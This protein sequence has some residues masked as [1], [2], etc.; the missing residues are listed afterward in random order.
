M[1]EAEIISSQLDFLNLTGASGV[2]SGDHI[3]AAR[4]LKSNR[5][6]WCWKRKAMDNTDHVPGGHVTR[7]DRPQNKRQQLTYRILPCVEAVGC[8]SLRRSLFLLG[9]NQLS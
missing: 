2:R 1:L 5:G 8:D 7:R 3:Y 4:Y 9:V 6:Q